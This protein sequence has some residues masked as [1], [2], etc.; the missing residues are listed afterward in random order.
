[1]KKIMITF[2]MIGAL[3]FQSACANEGSKETYENDLLIQEITKEMGEEVVPLIENAEEEGELQDILRVIRTE[4]G[5]YVD[6]YLSTAIPW[7][8]NAGIRKNEK[9]SDLRNIAKGYLENKRKDIEIDSQQFNDLIYEWQYNDT[10]Q[11]EKEAG[12][13][14]DA[15]ALYIYMIAYDENDMKYDEN[16]SRETVE[17]FLIR[18]AKHNYIRENVLI[19][20][21]KNAIDP[22]TVSMNNTES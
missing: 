21:D 15:M 7:I 6:S 2:F 9:I 18:I 11:F 17:D 14:R 8:E 1:M 20:F 3:L 19:K 4:M 16:I 12:S 10:N 22:T 13:N 5:D